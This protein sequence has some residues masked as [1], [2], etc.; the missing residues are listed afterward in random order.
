MPIITATF[1]FSGMVDY[2][3]GDGRR[4]DDNAGC[5]F[6]SYS[7]DTTLRDIVDGW[8]N[9]FCAGGDCDTLPEDVTESDV[10]AAILDMFTEQG[11][12]DYESGA[13]AECA[14]EFAECNDLEAGVPLDDQED[15]DT[16]GEYPVCIVLIECETCAECGAWADLDDDDLCAE[17]IAKHDAVDRDDPNAYDDH[18]AFLARND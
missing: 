6:T 2:W 4:W 12:A 18:D 9:D 10:R 7:T 16:W 14:T 5:L 13:L 8:V 15:E 17:C 11:R 1:E 3:G